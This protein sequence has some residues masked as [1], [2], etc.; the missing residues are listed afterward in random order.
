MFRG[1]ASCRIFMLACLLPPA[2]RAEWFLDAGA[3]LDYDDN[4]PRAED[5]AD[6]EGGGFAYLNAAPGR[7][8][9]FSD[10]SALTLS[11]DFSAAKYSEYDGL[12]SYS[13]GATAAVRTKFGLGARAPWA[14]VALAAGR[15]DFD[16]ALRDGWHWSAALAA[17]MRVGSRWNVQ[18]GWRYESRRSDDVEDIPFLV[19]NFGIGGEA[20]DVDAHNLS[21]DAV[22]EVNE[23]LALVLGYTRRMGETTA[24]TRIGPAVFEA[25][26]AIAPDAV[27][28]TDRFAYRVDADTNIFAAGLSWATGDHG[29]LNA[30]YEYQDSNADKG[31]SYANHVAH[32]SAVFS[33]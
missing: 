6:I 32:F 5:D 11:G 23:R 8:W 30:G 33:F 10:R 16:H 15:H 14:R 9:Q 26:D 13:W 1:A 3:G 4:L 7:F 22:F 28:G 29:S 24:T 27:F 2:A 25:S 31:F 20:W 19:E 21:L 12:D 17:G 18:A